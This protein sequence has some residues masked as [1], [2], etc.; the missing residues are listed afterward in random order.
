M[1]ERLGVGD[2]SEF[3]ELHKAA[4]SGEAPT[5]TEAIVV[6]EK[7]D[8]KIVGFGTLRMYPVL[9]SFWIDPKYQG[10]GMLVKLCTGILDQIPKL[11]VCFAFTQSERSVRLFELMGMETL[12]DWRIL[13]WVRR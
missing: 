5:Q 7:K 3:A 13:K 10:K 11:S 8:G 2:W 1:A 9:E 4:F 6:V 12:K